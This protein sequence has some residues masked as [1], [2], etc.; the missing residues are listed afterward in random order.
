M[1]WLSFLFLPFHIG[2]GMK[3]IS[4]SGLETQSYQTDCFWENSASYYIDELGRRGFDWLRIPFSASYVERGDFSILDNIFDSAKKWNMSILLDWHR[5]R[6]AGWQGDWLDDLNHDE[7]LRIYIQLLSRYYSRIELQMVGIFN[8]YKL[9]DSGF[10]KKEMEHSVR[11]LETTFPNRFYWLIGCPQWSGNCHDIDWSF[12]PFHDR[13]FGDVHKYSWSFVINQDEY[14]SDWEYS[15]PK[16]RTQVVVGEWGFLSDNSQQVEWAHR[17]IK[18]LQN[19]NIDKTCF[20]M[21][22]SSSGDTGG[23]WKDC[24]IFDELKYNVLLELWNTTKTVE[25]RTLRTKCHKLNLWNCIQQH[26]CCY[27][28]SGCWKCYGGME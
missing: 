6:N 9:M 5:N 26:D 7:Y 17:F 15:F 10:W 13:V 19:N 18:W 16:N 24:H 4:L 1:K 8:E 27:N 14:E 22:V 11:Y 12:L 2:L 28:F 23:I 25:K 21:S 20:W 3:C